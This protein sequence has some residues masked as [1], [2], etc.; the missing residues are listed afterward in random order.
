MRR[1]IGG[2]LA[3]GMGL[4]VQNAYAGDIYYKYPDGTTLIS[5]ST[6]PDLC[7]IENSNEKLYFFSKKGSAPRYLFEYPVNYYMDI[8]ILRNINQH[9]NS[10]FQFKFSYQN[11]P[12]GGIGHDLKDD[13]KHLYQ[14]DM[15]SDNYNAFLAQ[16]TSQQAISLQIYF[17]DVSENNNTSGL[18]GKLISSGKRKKWV[19]SGN[20]N[21]SWPNF[22]QDLKHFQDCVANNGPAPGWTQRIDPEVQQQQQE[23]KNNAAQAAYSNAL[24]VGSFLAYGADAIGKSVNVKGSPYCRDLNSCNLIDMN[25]DDKRVWFNPRSLSVQVRQ[26]LLK[27]NPYQT[28]TLDTDTICIAIISGEANNVRLTR[29]GENYIEP[30]INATHIQFLSAGNVAA[31]YLKNVLNKIGSS[32]PQQ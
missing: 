7:I 31:G 11:Q 21:I 2:C 5:G 28:N 16:L 13:E 6:Q 3:V 26:R 12:W 17:Q 19:E 14:L 25:D 27:C 32:V 15:N 22:S 20:V 23:Q 29:N 18:L 30:G 4:F 1:V 9:I 8:R 10:D 24:D